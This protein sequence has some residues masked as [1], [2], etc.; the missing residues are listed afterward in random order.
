MARSNRPELVKDNPAAPQM[1]VRRRKK[2]PRAVQP[3]SDD[4]GT[5]ADSLQ[6]LTE[7]AE[8]FLSAVPRWKRVES[9]RDA[10]LDAITQAQLLLSVERM[11][12]RQSVR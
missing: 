9:E 7:A 10:L 5:Y 6:T 2:S 1:Y 11:P 12:P 3:A 4:P 8:R